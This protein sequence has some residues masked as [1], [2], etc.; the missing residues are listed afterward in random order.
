MRI[1]KLAPV[2]L[3]AAAR[4]LSATADAWERAAAELDP[5]DFLRDGTPFNSVEDAVALAQA[6]QDKLIADAAPK[7]T[8]SSLVDQAT[9]TVDQMLDRV[10]NWHER[11]DPS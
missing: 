6:A 9:E 11:N 7:R 8:V 1:A 3:R 2:V 10:Q 4:V 5:I